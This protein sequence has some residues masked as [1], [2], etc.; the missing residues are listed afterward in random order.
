M[1]KIKPTGPCYA[2]FAMRKSDPELQSVKKIYT[3]K[4]IKIL[5]EERLILQIKKSI[6]HF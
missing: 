3:R 1:K 5:R 6:W 4:L 2:T